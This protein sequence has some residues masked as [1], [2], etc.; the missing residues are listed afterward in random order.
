MGLVTASCLSSHI[1]HVVSIFFRVLA[2]NFGGG[3]SHGAWH[4]DQHIT[5]QK[6]KPTVR[7]MG[8]KIGSGGNHPSLA[9]VF[10][11]ASVVDSKDLLIQEYFGNVASKQPSLSACV[12]TVKVCCVSNTKHSDGLYQ[13]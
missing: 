3:A 6:T 2:I 12:V 11:P 4:K 5:L 7:D 9:Q 10:S 1:S 8:T 13:S